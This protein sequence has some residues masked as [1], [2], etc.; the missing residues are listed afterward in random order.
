MA[1]LSINAIKLFSAYSECSINQGAWHIYYAALRSFVMRLFDDTGK[2]GLLDVPF[3]INNIL[4]MTSTMMYLSRPKI[5][6]LRL[7]LSPPVSA[8][9]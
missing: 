7:C 4:P 8:S 1:A 2:M 3:G 5:V 9:T 6:A